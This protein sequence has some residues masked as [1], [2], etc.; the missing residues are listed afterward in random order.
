MKFVYIQHLIKFHLSFKTLM[1]SILLQ[2]V[3][4]MRCR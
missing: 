2:K 4:L 1:K 3:A